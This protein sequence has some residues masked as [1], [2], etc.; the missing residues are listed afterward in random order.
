MKLLIFSSECFFHIAHLDL[1]IKNCFNK[2]L[3]I[4]AWNYKNLD[5]LKPVCSVSKLIMKVCEDDGA[6]VLRWILIKVL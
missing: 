2:V 1:P 3:I 4:N 5:F 6:A